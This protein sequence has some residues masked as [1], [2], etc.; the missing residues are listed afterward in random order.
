MNKMINKMDNIIGCEPV[1]VLV[2]PPSR[3]ALR[4]PVGVEVPG[5]R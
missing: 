3:L 2:V 5:W 4:F 1:Y